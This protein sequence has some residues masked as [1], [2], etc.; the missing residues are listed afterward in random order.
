MPIFKR[1]IPPRRQE[2][3]QRR[4]GIHPVF[5]QRVEH[6]RLLNLLWARSMRS[7]MSLDA[8]VVAVMVLDE[9]IGVQQ[10][11]VTEAHSV[12]VGAGRHNATIPNHVW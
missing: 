7:S 2:W 11:D 5:K 4:C 3:H 10:L 6:G 1:H 12:S 8:P 9:Q